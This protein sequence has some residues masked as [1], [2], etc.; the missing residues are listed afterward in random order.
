M[1]LRRLCSSPSMSL[2]VILPICLASAAAAQPEPTCED[3]A[4]IDFGVCALVLG[5]GIIDGDCTLISGCESPVPLFADFQACEAACVP[6]CQDLAGIDFG[7]CEMIL[8]WGIIDGACTLISGCDSP[9]ALFASEEE[10]RDACTPTCDDLAGIDFGPCDAVLGFGVING[11][12]QE[13]SGCESPVP[14][15]PTQEACEEACGPIPTEER[16]WGHIKSRFESE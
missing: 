13:I 12:C 15:F 16:S 5:V 11:A 14:L 3:L 1:R 2:S 6:T 10:C 9:V 7:D 4:G 8:G